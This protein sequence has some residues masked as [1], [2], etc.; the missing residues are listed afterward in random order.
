LLWVA[1][2]N[3]R[4][5]VFCPQSGGKARSWQTLAR[6]QLFGSADP[7]RERPTMQTAIDFILTLLMRLVGAVM[8]VI[9]IVEHGLR[10]VLEQAGVHGEL[11]SAILVVA[12]IVV[13]VA[14]LR[15][16]GGV[17]GFLITILLL[18]MILNVLMPG[19]HLP[20]SAHI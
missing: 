3:V 10:Q 12:A 17:F 14:A 2:K 4:A 9:G 5:T 15:L 18:L 1:V 13:I 8:A 11:Q 20:N 16:L 7:S 6:R 19:L